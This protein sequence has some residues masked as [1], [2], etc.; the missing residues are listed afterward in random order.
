VTASLRKSQQKLGRS[1]VAGSRSLAGFNRLLPIPAIPKVSV[2]ATSRRPLYLPAQIRR[3]SPNFVASAIGQQFDLLDPVHAEAAEG[4]TGFAPGGEG[5]DLAPEE[6]TE[7]VD[8]VFAGA[9]PQVEVGERSLWRVSL[10]TRC[11]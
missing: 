9:L 1:Q 8:A 11:T 2:A 3:R 5:P 6:A 4:F 10:A 7:G